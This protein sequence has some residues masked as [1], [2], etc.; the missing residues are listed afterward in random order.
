MEADNRTPG[1]EF[2]EPAAVSG[3]D[4]A[5]YPEAERFERPAGEA[6]RETQS[7]RPV[8]RSG[9]RKKKRTAKERLYGF[10]ADNVP[11]SGD[12]AKETVRKVVRLVS[13]AALVGA[14]AYLAVYGVKYMRHKEQIS[15]FEEQISELEVIEEK[16][17][18][19]LKDAWKNLRAE[20]P[21]V[22]FPAGMQIKLAR[23]YAVNQD[24][25]GWLRIPNTG[26][27]TPLVQTTNNSYYLSHDIY[28]R[29]SRYGNPFISYECTVGKELGQN[30][31]VFGHNLHDGSLFHELTDYMTAEG[32]L[33]APLV[34]VDTLYETTTWKIFAVILTNSTAE[35]DNGNVFRYLYPSFSTKSA[36][37]T[38]IDQIFA[39]SMIHTGVDVQ[40]DD[41]ILTLY[42]CNQTYF[43]GGRLVVFARQL[44][45]GESAE[46]DAS[47]VYY[48]S[49][50]KFPAAYYSHGRT[51]PATDA[52]EAE[53]TRAAS[54]DETTAAEN[55]SVTEATGEA[56]EETAGEEAP[57]AET[58]PE[59]VSEAEETEAERT[60]EPQEEPPEEDS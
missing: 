36:F 2:E 15:T 52:A 29:Q 16:G 38:K 5:L 27:S 60:Q 54:A 50:A 30:T 14:L 26:I 59:D 56:A 45:A 47:Q 19:A 22:E 25:V 6:A 17:G 21:D 9:I 4:A 32:Y 12:G 33:K 10:A 11:R 35:G 24:L 13:L 3:M 46:I 41:R 42:T 28:G 23:L 1:T 58:E 40:E 8:K 18:E 55:G 49:S 39:R 51:Q 44:R 48:D 37:M 43:S 31:I 34:T 20:Y 7:S 53:P 57:E